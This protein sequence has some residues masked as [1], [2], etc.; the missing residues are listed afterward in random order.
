MTEEN[1]NFTSMQ[2]TATVTDIRE[3][4]EILSDLKTKLFPQKDQIDWNSY[5]LTFT[6]IK[7]STNIEW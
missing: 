1:I 2:M 4:I 7:H 6:L 5:V 3:N